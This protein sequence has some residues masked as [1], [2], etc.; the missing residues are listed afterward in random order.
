MTPMEHLT[1]ERPLLYMAFTLDGG[2]ALVTGAVSVI[3]KERAFALAQAGVEGLI[4]DKNWAK[5]PSFRATAVHVDVSDET[6]VDNIGEVAARDYGRIDYSVHSAGMSQAT[7]EHLKIH[8]YDQTMAINAKG[9]ML[10]LRAV[11]AAM[12]NQKPRMHQS[13]RHGTWRSCGRDSIVVLRSINGT[14]VAPGMF[15]YVASKYA[16]IGIVK[17][18]SSLKRKHQ[19]EPVIENL[20]SLKRAALPEEIADPVVFLCSPAASYANG[21]TLM[22]DSGMS[23]SMFQNS[24]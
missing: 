19:L 7:I 16:V 24:L 21:T 3:W 12:A 15:S 10:V 11:E 9:T 17:T 6:T 20:T 8:V 4:E 23:P 18:A 22:I 2:I 1:R 5:H 13:P 14:M